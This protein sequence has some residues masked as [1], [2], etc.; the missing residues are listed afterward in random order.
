LFDSLFASA[1]GAGFSRGSLLSMTVSP[2]TRSKT[3]ILEA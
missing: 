3:A 1:A 2:C